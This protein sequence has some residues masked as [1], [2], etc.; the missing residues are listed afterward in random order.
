MLDP[1]SLWERD[2]ALFTAS[3]VESGGGLC[4]R[5]KAEGANCGGSEA[6][7]NGVVPPAC[8]KLEICALAAASGRNSSEA[9]RSSGERSC[10]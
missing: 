3:V 4:E 9:E 6:L 7:F 1:E 2:I 8:S 10:A 5:F